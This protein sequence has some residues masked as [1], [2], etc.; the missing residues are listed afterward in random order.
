MTIIQKEGKSHTNTD[1]LGRWPLDNVKSNPAYDPEV[2]SK[3]PIRFME[4]G[5]KKNFRFSE[6]AQTPDS[7]DTE[8]EGTET[9]ILG[10]RSYKLNNEFCS[11]VMNTYAKKKQC[12]IL[13]QLLQQKYRIPELESQLE[14]TWL[15]D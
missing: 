8:S 9:P 11:A 12:D 2:A 1:G 5:R 13:L 4:I 3:I 14:E 15:R 10:I 7:E 6:W